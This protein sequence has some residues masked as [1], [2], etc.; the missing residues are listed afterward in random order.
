MK[1]S[2]VILCILVLSI[3]DQFIKI[4]IDLRF[5]ETTF[6]IIPG[7][8]EFK[9]KYNMNYFYLNEVLGLGFKFWP[10][11]LFIIA[12]GIIVFLL[13][14]LLPYVQFRLNVIATAFAEI[15]PCDWGNVKPFVIIFVVL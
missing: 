7:L 9:P 1:K 11:I 15:I 6:E 14:K 13:Y 3:I 12:I 4:V 2:H 5:L 8:I 10:S